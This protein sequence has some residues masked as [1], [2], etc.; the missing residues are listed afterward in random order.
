MAASI[1]PL[2]PWPF[3][4]ALSAPPAP[5]ASQNMHQ[6]WGIQKQKLGVFRGSANE[7]LPCKKFIPKTWL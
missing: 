5:V 6:E 7:D 1:S 4:A 3:A 2:A